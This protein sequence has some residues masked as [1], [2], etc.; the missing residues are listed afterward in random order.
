MLVTKVTPTLETTPSNK[1]ETIKTTEAIKSIAL[2]YVTKIYNTT[3]EPF[4]RNV[5]KK[6]EPCELPSISEFPGDVFTQSQRRHG[7]LILH[8][9]VALYMFVGLAIV[10]DYYFVS[11]LEVIVYKLNLQADVAGASLMAIGSSAPELFASLIGI[12]TIKLFLYFKQKRDD[13]FVKLFI[14]VIYCK[15]K[16]GKCMGHKFV[17]NLSLLRYPS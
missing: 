13:K 4:H 2:S 3:F 8:L 7:G 16:K 12:R 17:E 9:I 11:S 15:N 14:T 6:P 5:T 10:C 1:S